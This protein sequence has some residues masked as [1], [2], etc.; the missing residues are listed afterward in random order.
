MEPL[1]E[2]FNK[3]FYSRLADEFA[4]VHKNFNP[5]KFILDVT[6]QIQKLPRLK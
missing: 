3:T 5:H 4:E 6:R 1:K 2:M